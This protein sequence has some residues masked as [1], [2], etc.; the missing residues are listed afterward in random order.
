M[1]L[2]SDICSVDS[3]NTT[4]DPGSSSADLCHV[5]LN[6]YDNSTVSSSLKKSYCYDSYNGNGGHYLSI[7]IIA[8]MLMGLGSVPL[9]VLGVT[10]IDDSAPHSAAA[11]H[12]GTSSSSFIV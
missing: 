11:F 8:A 10:Y 3:Y 4:T 12:L 1:C 7:F 9:Y 5:T 2:L 6:V